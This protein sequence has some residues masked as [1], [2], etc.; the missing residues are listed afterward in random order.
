MG[1]ESSRDLVLR[2][3]VRHRS[4]L[5]SL[6]LSLTRDFAF[7]EEVMQEVAIV[8]CDQWADF[9]PGSNFQ[10]WAMRIARN[11]IHNLTRTERRLIL[12]SP[13]AIE[14]VE[15]AAA[16][17]TSDGWL[18][19]VHHCLET[20]EERSRML[21]SLRYRKGQS[22]EEIARRLSMTVPAVHMAL[23]RARASIG[24]CVQGRLAE[25]G[26]SP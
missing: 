15:R 6:I 3:F 13:E 2:E 17:E 20:V 10:A 12:L 9:R 16:E 11:K 5:F 1:V 14:G 7:A 4:S 18:E 8:V 19:A 21:L 25:G 26:L 23:S 24:R 22:G